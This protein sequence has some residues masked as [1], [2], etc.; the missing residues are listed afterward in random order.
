[1]TRMGDEEGEG[2]DELDDAKTQ[3]ERK[4]FVR[5]SVRRILD[6]LCVEDLYCAGDFVFFPGTN[7]M[8]AKSRD[9]Y[10]FYVLP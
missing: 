7:C 3:T 6:C 10:F 8:K 5:R 1:M 4:R 2:G 9:E